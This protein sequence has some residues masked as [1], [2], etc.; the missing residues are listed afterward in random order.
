MK[1]Q[2]WNVGCNKKIGLRGNKKPQLQQYFPEKSKRNL[3]SRVLP[4]SISIS[5]MYQIVKPSTTTPEQKATI[6]I[7]VHLHSERTCARVQNC[8]LGIVKKLLSLLSPRQPAKLDNDKVCQ[9]LPASIDIYH[10]HSFTPPASQAERM[11]WNGGIQLI[12]FL[13]FPVF[14]NR[15]RKT[16]SKV[17]TSTSAAALAFI[18]QAAGCV[19][20]CACFFGTR[21][22]QPHGNDTSRKHQTLD[23]L[24]RVLRLKKKQQPPPVE[25]PF[26]CARQDREIAF[27][28]LSTCFA[29]F[30]LRCLHSSAS[31]L[32]T[33]KHGCLPRLYN[34]SIEITRTRASAHS[35]Q[36][37]RNKQFRPVLI[38]CHGHI[39]LVIVLDSLK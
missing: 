28:F 6:S 25:R 19:C 31:K 24:S 11:P 14:A 26:N 16:L 9:Q 20:V 34:E 36:S 7:P 30:C 18:L 29:C 12:K 1:V 39:S 5:N 17:T 8:L 27:R 35:A 2:S 10:R 21:A 22:T 32:A 3:S 4:C 38:V 13:R 37:E 33:Q 23:N 15:R